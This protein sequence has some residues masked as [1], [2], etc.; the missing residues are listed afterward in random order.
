MTKYVLDNCVG[1][2]LIS[3]QSHQ[4]WVGPNKKTQMMS[5]VKVTFQLE[6]KLL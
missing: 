6:E 2:S 4:V 1:F 3:T 5:M